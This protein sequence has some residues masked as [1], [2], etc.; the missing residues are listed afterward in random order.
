MLTYRQATDAPK[1][2]LSTPLPDNK[3]PVLGNHQGFDKV[4]DNFLVDAL[5]SAEVPIATVH[6]RLDCLKK[7]CLLVPAT[8]K[9]SNGTWVSATILVNTGAMANFISKEF[10]CRHKLLV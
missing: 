1:S 9:S 4:Y 6:V 8:F 2:D 7:G 5:E 10:V 3:A